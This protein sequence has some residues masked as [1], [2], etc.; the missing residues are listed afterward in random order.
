MLIL[1]PQAK[2]DVGSF[3]SQDC[4]LPMRHTSP[5]SQAHSIQEGA[6]LKL[7]HG[8][9]TFQLLAVVVRVWECRSKRHFLYSL[10]YLLEK[11]L[12]YF[13]YLFADT[14]KTLGVTE[15]RNSTCTVV[16]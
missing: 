12:T 13:L 16:T 10:Q 15:I 4:G 11:T 7:S 6:R 3:T 2:P 9:A 14:E 8:L 1:P 5:G